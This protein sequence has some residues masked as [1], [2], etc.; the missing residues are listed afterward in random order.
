MFCRLKIWVY[1]RVER[2]FRLRR[3]EKM[4][5]FENERGE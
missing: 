1:E 3:V 2:E 4:R 5:E